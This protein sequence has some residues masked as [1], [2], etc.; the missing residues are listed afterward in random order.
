M[1]PFLEAEAVPAREDTWIVIPRVSRESATVYEHARLAITFT[2][3]HIGANGLPLLRAG[4]WNDGI[5]ALGRREI[6][7]SVWMGFFL[8][9]VLGGFVGLARIKDD[10]AFATRCE[11]EFA[12]QQKALGGGL[13]GRPLRSRLRRRRTR[14]RRAQRYGQRLGRLFRRLRRRARAG[15]H[16]GRA[17]GIERANRV[18]LHE[19][20]FYEHSKPY[21]GRIADYPPGVRENGGQYSHGATWIVD[22]FMR[23]AA[24][25]RAKGNRELAAHLGQR[26]F[27]I[28][29][30]ISPLKKTDPENLAIYGLIPTPAAGRCLRRLGPRRARGLVVVH[31]LGR[32]HAIGG[33][34]PP[35]IGQQ[36][37]R[38]VLRDD[39]F[40]ARGN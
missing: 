26:A 9:N 21:P 39:L 8:A 15:R 5:D 27:E 4:D 18:L 1:T 20:P 28:Y 37:G 2:L 29:E 32:S 6:G 31:G 14:G 36:D 40:E 10:E 11:Q 17:E 3:E 33:L 38:V 34:C 12:A 22:G 30:K 24:S 16:R 23:L 19:S 13:D 25:A 35:G 7:T